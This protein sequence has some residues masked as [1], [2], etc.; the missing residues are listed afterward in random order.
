[1][2]LAVPQAPAAPVAGGDGAS[3]V[4]PWRQGQWPRRVGDGFA[5][6]LY[7][8]HDE[9]EL[10]RMRGLQRC[11]TFEAI[12]EIKRRPVN[13]MAGLELHRVRRLRAHHRKAVRPALTHA[14]PSSDRTC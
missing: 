1:M 9:A 11:A 12:E 3:V 2:P 8:P 13:I 6:A 10:L 5:G 4:P 14:R 7:Q